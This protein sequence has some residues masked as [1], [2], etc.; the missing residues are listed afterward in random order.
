MTATRGR[1]RQGEEETM[2]VHEAV[3]AAI[4]AGDD[5][6]LRTLLDADPAAADACDA[7]G[8]S[9]LLTALYHGHEPLARMIEARRRDAVSAF[10]AAALGRTARLR[11]LLDT[12]PGLVTRFSPDGWTLLH[13]AAFFGRDEAVALLLEAG[14]DPNQPSVNTLRNTALHAAAAGPLS[15]E[16]F[17]ALLAA[18]A[19]PNVRQPGGYV[20]LHGVAAL[21]AVDRIRLLLAHG[22]HPH[23]ATDD[24]RTA[25]DLAEAAG[26]EDA[27]ALLRSAPPQI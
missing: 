11:E 15:A 13:L 9:A 6:A 5:G 24:G 2:S 3:V 26:H 19:D 21:G 22:A 16:G 17:R 10:E 12:K 8:V 20:P 27:A 14:A 25:L 23:S 7:A 4:A 18:G 1:I